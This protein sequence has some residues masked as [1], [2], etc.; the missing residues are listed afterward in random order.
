[1]PSAV[2]PTVASAS[3]SSSTLPA[4]FATTSMDQDPAVGIKRSRDVDDEGDQDMH[5]SSLNICEC[6]VLED[7]PINL[8]T[9]FEKILGTDVKGKSTEFVASVA[10]QVDAYVSAGIC[11]DISNIDEGGCADD[12]MV[13]MRPADNIIKTKFDANPLEERVV[14]PAILP[15][16]AEWEEG[17]VV[18][19]LTGEVLLGD[20][21]KLAKREEITEM[22]RRSVWSET[23]SAECIEVTGKPPV[24]VRWVIVNKGDKTRYNVRAR[25]VA[26][27]I[28]AKYGGKG[29]HELFAA[30]PP[31][32]MVK[33][34]LVR[35]VSSPALVR[36]PSQKLGKDATRKV[37]FIDVSKAHLYALID[38]NVDAYV[39]LPPECRKQGMCGRLNYWLYGMRPASKG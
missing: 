11:T 10:S 27:H 38:A 14:P 8:L 36:V 22:Y 1:M 30:M 39:D 4:H 3:S 17:R 13:P 28:V 21:V 35:A 2:L 7:F 18:D 15:T 29:I 19:D 37:M 12:Y 33:L 34:L 23:S 20:L 6:L 26:K 5:L 16:F 31:F 32:E 25:L 24:P 9:A